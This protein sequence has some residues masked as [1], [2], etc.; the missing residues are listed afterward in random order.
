MRLCAFDVSG[1]V[2][3]TD[4]EFYVKNIRPF[5]YSTLFN[6]AF[7]ALKYESTVLIN[8]PFIQEVRD[9]KYISELKKRVEKYGAQLI[10]IWITASANVCYERKKF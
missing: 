4:G 7:T 1:Q 9:E 8:A 2:V 10:L 5:E 6:L 3:D